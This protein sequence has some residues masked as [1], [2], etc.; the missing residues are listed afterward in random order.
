MLVHPCGKPIQLVWF[1]WA[2]CT[3]PAKRLAQS[4]LN[5]WSIWDA[6]GSVSPILDGEYER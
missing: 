6:F 4:R 2:A 1:I 3:V 5:A